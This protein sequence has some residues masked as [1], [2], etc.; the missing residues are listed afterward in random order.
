MQPS[1]VTDLVVALYRH[2]EARISSPVVRSSTCQYGNDASFT[3]NYFEKYRESNKIFTVLEVLT[4]RSLSRKVCCWNCGWAVANSLCSRMMQMVEY[5]SMPASC[6]RG[7]SLVPSQSRM[8]S[9][10]HFSAREREKVLHSQ[11]PLAW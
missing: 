4:T 1:M 7:E 5:T 2:D 8:T 3:S 10:P 11:L 6:N 9:A